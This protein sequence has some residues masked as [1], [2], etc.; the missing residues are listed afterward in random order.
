MEDEVNDAGD[1]CSE[2]DAS[3]RE[4]AGSA[5]DDGDDGSPDSELSGG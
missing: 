3:D 1:P 4:D 5:E 2:R